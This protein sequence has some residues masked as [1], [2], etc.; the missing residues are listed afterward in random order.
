MAGASVLEEFIQRGFDTTQDAI[1]AVI[2]STLDH[3][4]APGS[5]T[6]TQV[7]SDLLDAGGL[8]ATD[9]GV[10]V[11]ETVLTSSARI[12]A[13]SYTADQVAELLG[14]D[15]TRVR[16]RAAQGSL[17]QILLGRRRYFPA[18]QFRDGKVL[19]GLAT[20][21]AAFPDPVH[22][23]SLTAFMTTPNADLDGMAPTVWLATGG[24]P[25]QVAFE[26]GAL[27]SW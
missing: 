4:A 26:V 27:T 24:F 9:E 14:I 8:A 22:P 19:P 18:W 3:Y 21:L 6:L 25:E 1:I 12:I 13:E 5:T 7:E 10:D 2:S 17:Y 23:L 11:V 16:H 15:V 20:V